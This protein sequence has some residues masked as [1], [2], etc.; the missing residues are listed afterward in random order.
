MVRDFSGGAVTTRTERDEEGNENITI[1]FRRELNDMISS[2]N[3][4]GAMSSRFGVT[5][6]R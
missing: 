5:P 2:G 1:D 4:D 3:V 6:Q